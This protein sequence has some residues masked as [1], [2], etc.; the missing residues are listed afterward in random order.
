MEELDS[1]DQLKS[2]SRVDVVEPQR[3]VAREMFY[4]ALIHLGVGEEAAN[5]AM[6]ETFT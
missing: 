6:H 5:V 3:E 4:K 1:R 2:F